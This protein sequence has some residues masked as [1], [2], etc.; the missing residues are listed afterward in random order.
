MHF[1]YLELKH[2]FNI[3]NKD[4]LKLRFVEKTLQEI[5]REFK[6]Y[7]PVKVNFILL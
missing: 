7:I 4:F 3:L 2:A 6:K 5:P 1:N